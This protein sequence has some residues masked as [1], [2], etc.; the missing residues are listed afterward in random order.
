MTACQQREDIG[1]VFHNTYRFL[2]P[3]SLNQFC[4]YWFEAAYPARI[5][6]LMTWFKYTSDT[7][8]HRKA[9]YHRQGKACPQRDAF[10]VIASPSPDGSE[11]AAEQSQGLFITRRGD[12]RAALAMT[13]WLVSPSG[14][15]DSGTQEPHSGSYR[16]AVTIM[17]WTPHN[18]ALTLVG[19]NG[20][21]AQ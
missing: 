2:Y 16:G 1:R 8:C 17:S 15:N 20:K 12:C 18:T 6:K 3:G 7:F 19:N 9:L 10:I 21:L 11:G 14:R 5:D 4:D 13:I